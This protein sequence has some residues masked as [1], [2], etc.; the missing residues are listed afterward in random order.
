MQ[1]K[2]IKLAVVGLGYVGLPLAAEFG[3]QRPVVGFDI[4]TQRIAE[5]T[6]GNDRTRELTSEQL[7]QTTL[8]SRTQTKLSPKVQAKL[9]PRTQTKPSS[10][11]QTKLS[12][13]AQSQDLPKSQNIILPYTETLNISA[14]AQFTIQVE[15]R[16][17]VQAKLQERGIP[18]A[19]HYPIPL[20]KQPAVADAS[21]QLPVGDVIAERVI[22]LSMHPYMREENVERV[23]KAVMQ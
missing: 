16:D 13:C 11:A 18:T 15:N 10:N 1:L 3:K 6:A 9:S 23:V 7:A 21:A 14:W 12:S 19:V 17:A 4:N 8:S 20:N 5:L 2:D 22:S